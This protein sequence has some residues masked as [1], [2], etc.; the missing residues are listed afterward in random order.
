MRQAPVDETGACFAFEGS[1][2]MPRADSQRM[3]ES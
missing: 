2:D 3:F 1:V